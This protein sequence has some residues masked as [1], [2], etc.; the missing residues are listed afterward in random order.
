MKK[1]N[2]VPIVLGVFAFA[3][4]SNQTPLAPAR[5]TGERNR[6]RD[7]AGE[8]FHLDG[9]IMKKLAMTLLVCVL[10]MQHAVIAQQARVPRIAN[11][12]CYYRVGDYG[13][14]LIDICE[15]QIFDNSGE[16]YIGGESPAWSPD[17]LRIAYV[18]ERCATST[19][20]ISRPTPVPW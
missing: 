5:R 7:E 12:W 2:L 13:W 1:L 4:C 3:G 20:T 18:A 19:S 9:R 8:K 16:T 15:V 10:P 17:G 6:Q 11:D 14:I